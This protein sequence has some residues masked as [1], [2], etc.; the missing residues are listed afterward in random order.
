[1]EDFKAEE[2]VE[3]KDGK[4][5]EEKEVDDFEAEKVTEE[6]VAR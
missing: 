6:E 4:R 1:M 3:E 2:V 5:V